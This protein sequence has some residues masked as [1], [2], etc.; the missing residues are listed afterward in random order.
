M[1]VAYRRSRG[2]PCPSQQ[3]GQ[4]ERPMRRSRQ[5]TSLGGRPVTLVV[6]IQF[7]MIGKTIFIRVF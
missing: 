2:K 3:A 5:G 6:R 1:A 7:H 4:P